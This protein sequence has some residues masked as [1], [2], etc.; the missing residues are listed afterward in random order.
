LVCCP[1]AYGSSLT[2]FY[3]PYL[4][5]IL[6]F[7]V[8]CGVKMMSLRQYW[9]WEQPQ[10]AFHI[11][12]SLLQSF[13]VHWYAIHQHTVGALHSL[14]HPNFGRVWSIRP[15]SPLRMPSCPDIVT[16]SSMEALPQTPLALRM[17]SSRRLMSPLLHTIHNFHK[18]ICPCSMF[19][20][21]CSMFYV[22]TVLCF[23]PSHSPSTKLTRRWLL[24]NNSAGTGNGECNPNHF[25]DQFTV[26][27]C[28][29][30]SGSEW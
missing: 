28:L 5:Q 17:G 18:Y 3:P 9:G 7:R 6:G 10:T 20:V 8:T 14:T 26:S 25:W 24:Q 15:P 23:S 12:I 21:L 11:H 29:N 2:Q 16:S 22:C 30:P 1:L 4:A 13:W 19:Y 27:W